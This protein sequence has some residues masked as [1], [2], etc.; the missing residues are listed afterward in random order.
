MS[1][2]PIYLDNAATTP[3]DG[4]VLESMLPFLSGSFGNAA[5]KQHAMGRA[6]AGAVEQARGEVALL[7]GA[8]P[9]EI[10]FTSG[11]TEA[12]NLG[13]LGACQAEAHAQLP[14]R[15]L[16]ASTEHH[17]VLEPIDALEAQGF[18]VVRLP[19]NECGHLD[20]DQLQAELRK[21]L[22][23]VS[24][25][26]ANNELGVLHPLAEIG[27]LCREHGALFHTDAT[28]LVGKQP[29]DVD[30]AC[31]D[32]LSLS[33]HKFY[34]PKGVGALYLRRKRPRVRVNP[35]QL[36]GGH[37]SGRRSGTLNVPAIVGLGTAAALRAREAAEDEARIATLRDEFEAQLQAAVGEIEVNGDTQL[38]L[39]GHSNLAI[40][41]VDA[42]S[43]LSR[44]ERVCASSGSACT[45]ASQGPSHVLRA[46]GHSGA[47]VR[48]SLRFSL[49][50][51]TQAAQIADAVAELR[52]AVRQERAEGPQ[53][54][55]AL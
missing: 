41:G 35:L 14:R 40:A 25:M 49:G 26:G 15:V 20:L 29:L 17:A 9:R 46:L 19:V 45:S 32:L 44:L 52:Q 7:I 13:L 2:A 24:L 31:I 21:G 12:N 38:R 50:K 54:I 33:A 53:D 36:G 51:D 16:T 18:E 22:R 55:C 39:A 23:L 42:E 8:D 30:S 37:E 4:R 3:L 34:G 10:V 47:R 48:S 28:Q 43:L 5:S 6:A 11:A 27:A 1:D